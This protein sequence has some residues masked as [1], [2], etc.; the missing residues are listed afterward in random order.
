[1]FDHTYKKNIVWKLAHAYY[2]CYFKTFSLVPDLTER[3]KHF[4][5]NNT[6]HESYYLKSN[7]I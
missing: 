3:T 2:L 1:M 4:L 7:N 5:P 6:V